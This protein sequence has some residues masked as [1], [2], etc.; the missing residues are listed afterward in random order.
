MM[1]TG[2]KMIRREVVKVTPVKWIRKLKRPML[3]GL[4][5]EWL[6]F[7]HRTD[8]L[9]NMYASIFLVDGYP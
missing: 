2:K 5:L 7:D 4:N 1:E 9:E 3:Y 8:S 6:P